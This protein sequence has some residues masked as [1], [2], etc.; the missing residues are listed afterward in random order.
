MYGLPIPGGVYD[1]V[2]LGGCCV[3]EDSPKFGYRCPVGGE[4]YF[5]KN[6]QL[7]LDADEDL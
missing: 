3:Y 7:V 6:G 4:A 1:D 2:I 5:L